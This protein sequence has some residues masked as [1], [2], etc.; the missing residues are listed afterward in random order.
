M[1]AL[2][3]LETKAINAAKSNAW[4]QAIEYN[5]QIIDQYPQD[6]NALNRLGFAY[7]QKQKVRLA[8]RT[9]QK[10]LTLEKSNPIATKQLANIKKKSISAP[11]FSSQNFV[12]EPSKSKIVALHRLAG[13]QALEKLNRSE[14]RR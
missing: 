6:I 7:L 8:S 3:Q 9:F 2:R 1:S 5:Q 4:D 13:K 11:E 10:V 12:E 14:E